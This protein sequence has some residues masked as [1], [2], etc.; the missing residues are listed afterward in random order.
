MGSAQA[1]IAR[2]QLLRL[3]LAPQLILKLAHHLLQ[4]RV[5]DLELREAADAPALPRRE[6]GVWWRL[7]R[8]GAQPCGVFMKEF[9]ALL[10]LCALRAACHLSF[11]GLTCQMTNRAQGAS[12]L[13]Q[14][15][16]M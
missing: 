5:Q 3:A 1:L 12:L 10:R 8:G 4:V 14:K 11:L 13:N 6:A 9:A 15:A 2:S 16:A 7:A